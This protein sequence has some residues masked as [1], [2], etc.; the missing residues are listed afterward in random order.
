MNA[1]VTVRMTRFCQNQPRHKKKWDI[2]K[3]DNRIEKIE[4]FTEDVQNL[5]LTTLKSCQDHIAGLLGFISDLMNCLVYIMDG[6]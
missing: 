4:R 6:N 1:R 2:D 5:C 3:A